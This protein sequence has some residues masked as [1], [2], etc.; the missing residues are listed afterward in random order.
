MT[1]QLLLT[2][3]NGTKRDVSGL[4]QTIT[5]S[6][7]KRAISRSLHAILAAPKDGED[8]PRVAIGDGLLLALDGKPV[9]S[10]KIYQRSQKTEE[11]TADMTAFDGGSR[12]G[13]NDGT[14]RFTGASPEAITRTVCA[15]HGFAVASLPTTGARIRRIFAGVALTKI[16][17]TAWTLAEE[18]TGKHFTIC[19]TPEG[20]VVRERGVSKQSPIL[21]PRSNLMDAVIKEDASGCVSS[22]AIYD[23]HRNF[24]RRIDGDGEVAKLLG[25]M[26]KHI[27]QAKNGGAEA[28]A[29][30]KRL[31]EEGRIQQNIT[32]NV[33]GDPSLITGQTVV[34]EEEQT[35]LSGVFWVESDRHTWKNGQYFSAL[36][37]NCRNVSEHV[38]A[39]QEDKT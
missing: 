19:W 10:G 22:V 6:G 2:Q 14:Y 11:H 27:R 39:G 23:Q 13:R 15:D 33:L 37:L 7:D 31:L 4:Y 12:L 38:T 17:Q 28:D 30:A 5:W 1:L 18:Q 25:T 9:F 21:R 26:E 16:I 24:L 8:L 20:L 29:N 3:A 35:G 36:T 32:V 34:V